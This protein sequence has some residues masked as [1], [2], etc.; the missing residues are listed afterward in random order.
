MKHWQIRLA[1]G[2]VW[3]A[4][5]QIFQALCL[6]HWMLFPLQTTSGRFTRTPKWTEQQLANYHRP[7]RT[8]FITQKEQK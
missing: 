4:V 2:N 7:T 6:N 8:H 1:S 3:I 5:S